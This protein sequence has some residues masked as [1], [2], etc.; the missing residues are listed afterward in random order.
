MARSIA[1]N[2]ERAILIG[3]ELRKQPK[4]VVPEKIR[5]QAKEILGDLKRTTTT[6]RHE[7]IK[8]MLALL[9]DARLSDDVRRGI[10]RRSRAAERKSGGNGSKQIA[11]SADVHR[12]LT[13]IRSKHA[14]SMNSVILRLLED[15][16][17]YRE[18]KQRKCR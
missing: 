10:L 13:L 5:V 18:L 3:R 11:V 4:G 12:R 16:K 9:D 7:D 1:R 2:R 14:E 6:S 15:R 17:S 8:A